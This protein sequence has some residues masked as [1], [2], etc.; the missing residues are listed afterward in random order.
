MK[1]SNHSAMN[2]NLSDPL[3]GRLRAFFHKEIPNPWPD[4]QFPLDEQPAVRPMVRGSWMRRPMARFA[5][6][7]SIL[8]LVL[9]YLALAK[10]FP[11]RN[12]EAL[13]LNR[14]QEIGSNGLRWLVPKRFTTPRGGEAWLKE[15]IHQT[16]GERPTIILDLKEIKSQQR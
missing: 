16:P 11:D 14:S 4:F 8:L 7:A 12:G 5:M 15:S 3:E 6:A 10:F 2:G 9:G 1:L 13:N